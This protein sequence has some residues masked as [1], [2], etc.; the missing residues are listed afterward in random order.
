LRES[1]GGARLGTLW[2][3]PKI[4]KQLVIAAPADAVWQVLGPGFARIGE[5]ATAIPTSAALR[6]GTGLVDAPVAGRVC[7]TG[8]RMVPEVTE[9][10]T[11]YDAA[12]RTLT[13][14]A[15]GLPAFVTTARN[16]WTVTA[17]DR[18]RCR[19]SLDA[20]FDTRGVLG[21]VARW[22]L[23]VQVG[24]T[25]RHLADDLRHY[26][27]HGT[28]SPRKQRQQRSLRKNRSAASSNG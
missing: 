21:A 4:S 22:L 9:I 20:Q 28:P 3:V 18:R 14:A 8:L 12:N 7:A 11:A 17:L 6:V 16:T 27:E 13:Y 26:V 19:V 15:S 23:M 10:L 24:R 5:W 25:S 1:P 2:G